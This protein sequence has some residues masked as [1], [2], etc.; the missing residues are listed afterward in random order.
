MLI[1]DFIAGFFHLM[2][3]TTEIMQHHCET[4]NCYSEIINR[5]NNVYYYAFLLFLSMMSPFRKVSILVGGCF[6][7]SVYFYAKSIANNMH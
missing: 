4:N 6:V 2:P 1:H 7:V 3:G 5:R